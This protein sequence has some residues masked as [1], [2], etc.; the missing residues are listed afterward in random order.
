MQWGRGGQ[1]ARTGTG[2]SAIGLSGLSTFH[3]HLQLRWEEPVRSSLHR[4][5]ELKN[6]QMP[7]VPRTLAPGKEFKRRQKTI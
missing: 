6:D 1:S 2:G 3:T 5:H 7:R 4:T